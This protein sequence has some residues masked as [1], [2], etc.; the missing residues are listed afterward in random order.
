M[1]VKTQIL[2]R[3]CLSLERNVV[4]YV[5]KQLN[6]LLYFVPFLFFLA[7]LPSLFLSLFYSY[8]PICLPVLKPAESL[9]SDFTES[10]ESCF[11]PMQRLCKYQYSHMTSQFLFTWFLNC[12]ETEHYEFKKNRNNLKY[13]TCFK[14]TH[15]K[16]IQG[17]QCQLWQYNKWHQF[18]NLVE[19]KKEQYQ[20]YLGSLLK[21]RFSEPTPE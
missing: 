1:A 9:F 4:I 8:L 14:K 15:T 11:I 13:V 2:I 7:P 17:K 21:F 16:L 18:S 3:T 10:D 12:S 20:N 19:K 5:Q 6:P